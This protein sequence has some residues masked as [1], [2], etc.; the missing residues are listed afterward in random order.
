MLTAR[1][2]FLEDDLRGRDGVQIPLV[3]LLD[4]LR[5]LTV[6]AL[7]HLLLQAVRGPRDDE[8]PEGGPPSFG[9]PAVSFEE[10]AVLLYGVFQPLSAL[11]SIAAGHHDGREPWIRVELVPYLQY[12]AYLRGGVL[13]LRVVRLVD[14]EDVGYLHHARLECLDRVP[15]PRLQAEHHRVRGRGDLDFALAHADGLVED[16][17]VP[18][19]LHRDGGEPR[20]S[21]EPAKMS[22][23]PHRPDKNAGVEEVVR[24]PYAVAQDRTSRKRARRIDGDDPD[25]SV[26][27]PV[28]FYEL[29][30]DAALAD[31]RRRGEPYRQGVAGLLGDLRDN[32]GRLRVL[33]LYLGDNTR[34]RPPVARE[35]TFYQV[36]VAHWS[37]TLSKPIFRSY[38]RSMT[39]WYARRQ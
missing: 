35:Q 13:G 9:E 20:A 6:Q 24:E 30:D 19:G 22:P 27:L 4:E 14:A 28:E 7:V 39:I 8:V 38:F 2:D 34:Q 10:V 5:V 17:I 25:P 26:F 21:R 36:F 31:A 33:A 11:A 3:D 15:S 16:H 32:F 23:A 12:G 29:R 1:L 37:P 18:A